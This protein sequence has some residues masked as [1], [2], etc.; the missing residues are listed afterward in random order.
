MRSSNCIFINCILINL[1]QRPVK[2]T[3]KNIKSYATAQVHFPWEREGS[4]MAKSPNLSF[5]NMIRLNR[6]YYS[7]LK[8]S[9]AKLLKIWFFRAKFKQIKQNL[10]NSLIYSANCT[11]FAP[12]INLFVLC[13]RHLPRAENPAEFQRI[14]QIPRNSPTQSANYAKFAHFV[15]LF[16]I[17][18]QAPAPTENAQEFQRINANSTRFAHTARESREI[19]TIC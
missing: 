8:F 18:F 1:K 4:L 5:K 10:L 15:N 11:K 19:C 16:Y 7:L 14:T 6:T 3:G 17:M 2:I 9:Q 12:I 13:F